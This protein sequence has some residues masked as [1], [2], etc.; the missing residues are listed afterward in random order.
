MFKTFHGNKDA[1]GI[2]LFI[3]KNQIEAM[4][5]SIA[6]ES[7]KIQE[8]NL[9]LNFYLNNHLMNVGR[10]CIVDD[11]PIYV[12]AFKKNLIA[13]GIE[14]DLMIYDDGANSLKR[15]FE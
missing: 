9:P 1:K 14:Q 10:I 8:Q 2:G 3:T 6:I 12:Y 5:G 11:D 15:A 4:D 13:C 7:E